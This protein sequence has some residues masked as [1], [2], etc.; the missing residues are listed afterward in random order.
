MEDNMKGISSEGIK[1]L[2]LDL[3]EYSEEFMKIKEKLDNVEQRLRNCFIG[4]A[5]NS[6]NNSLKSFNNNITYLSKNI[7]NY[8]EF[9]QEIIRSYE[10]HDIE[11]FRR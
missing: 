3:L 2:S 4:E 6:Y 1:K 11:S 7:K 10:K 8:S 5:P 9:C